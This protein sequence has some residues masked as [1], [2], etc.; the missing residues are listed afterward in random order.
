M[1]REGDRTVAENRKARHDYSIIDSF[2]T[3]IELRGTE[4]KSLRAGKANLKDSYGVIKNGEL[5]IENMHISPYEHGNIYNVDPLRRRKLLMHKREIMKLLGQTR[6]KGLAL[7]PLK[8]YFT[9]G[10][11]KVELALAKGKKM[12]DKRES[13]AKKTAQ[14]EMSKVF[15]EKYR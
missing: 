11:A 6:E 4:V 15:K 14:R 8:I 2:E 9:R 7:I 5:F 3:G 13:D 12:Y 1:V 10:K